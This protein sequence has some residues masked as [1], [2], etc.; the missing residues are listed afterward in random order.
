MNHH[1][2]FDAAIF[3]R[4]RQR[5]FGAMGPGALL[6]H[7]PPEPVR[8][9][10]THY[11]FRQNSDLMYATGFNEPESAAL[12][13]NNGTERKFILFTRPRDKEKETWNGRRAGVEGAV[14]VYKADEAFVITDLEAKLEELLRGHA[15]FF[16]TTGLDEN[17]DLRILRLLRRLRPSRDEKPVGPS[18]LLDAHELVGELRLFKDDDDLFFM[19]RS[20][21]IAA[22][23]HVQA[24]KA[25]RPGMNES[26]IEALIEHEFRAGGAQCA[27]YNTI[28]GGGDNACILHYVENN[29]PLRDGDLLL[30]DAGC[31]YHG[32]AS[33][34]TRT[35][36][37]NGRFTQAQRE[38]YD[39]VLEAQLRVIAECRPGQTITGLHDIAVKTLTE[40]MIR[41]GMLKGDAGDNIANKHFR[42]FYMHRTGHW[43]GIDVHDCG[44][45]FLDGK[46]RP[47]EPGMVFTVEPGVYVAPDDVEAPEKYRGV[48]VRIED[49]ILITP[50]GHE[51]LTAG[52]PKEPRAIEELMRSSRG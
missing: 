30:I 29:M 16:H 25:A 52:V 48:G 34:I 11:K 50:G 36:P 4:R 17:L 20:A 44:K 1:W 18:A 43:L 6:L 39:L 45:Y 7:S 27:A 10:D 5:I 33:D 49:D 19:R 40:G 12:L 31:E 37:V 21:A 41:L 46:P 15:R 24:M 8:S 23:A 14:S 32:Y 38:I 51:V 42:R 3:Q 9:H 28:A 47:I 2:T 13:L 26:D 35:F 22:H